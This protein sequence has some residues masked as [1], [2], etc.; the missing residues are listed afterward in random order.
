MDADGHSDGRPACR[1]LFE[2]LQVHLVRLAAPALVL[3]EG[4][5]EQPRLAQGAEH[6]VGEALVGLVLSDP[7]R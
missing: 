4:E 3:G 1:Q 7:W 6:L 5:A 2:H